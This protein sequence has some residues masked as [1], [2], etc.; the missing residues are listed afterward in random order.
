MMGRAWLLFFAVVVPYSTRAIGCVGQDGSARDWWFIYKMPEN[1]CKGTD[2][3]LRFAY[4]DALT[5]G[6]ALQLVEGST[7]GD[8]GGA[9]GSTLAQIYGNKSGLGYAAYNDEAPPPGPASSTVFHAKGVLATDAETGGFFLS[10]SVPK[11]PD[12]SLDAFNW[13]A[14]QI[15]GQSFLCASFDVQNMDAVA[16]QLLVGRYG[17][18][19]FYSSNVPTAIA[20]AVPHLKLLVA[21]EGPSSSAAAAVSNVLATVGGQQQFTMYTKSAAWG[22]DLGEDLVSPNLQL[23][24]LWETWRRAPYTETSYCT[25]KITGAVNNSSSETYRYDSVNVLDITVGSAPENAFSY[26]KDHSK[27]GISMD[28][29]QPWVCESD[30]NRMTSQKKRGGG[31]ICF[32]HA[33]LHAA[34]AGVI[35]NTEQCGSDSDSDSGSGSSGA[36]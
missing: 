16:A 12:L 19:G 21:G 7:L 32:Q 29:A 17:A 23:G 9:L 31:C 35:G 26:T 11:F 3:S 30:I 14:S 4:I 24:F 2:C 20:A 10:H 28:R 5:A 1:G 27:W 36:R 6:S 15:Y 18:K 13:T 25:A 33:G 8:S 34:L 22:Q